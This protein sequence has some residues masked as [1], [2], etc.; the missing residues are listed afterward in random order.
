MIVLMS[1]DVYVINGIAHV[2]YRILSHVENTQAV[3]IFVYESR[4]AMAQIVT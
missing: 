3:C 1:N 2:V 4:R